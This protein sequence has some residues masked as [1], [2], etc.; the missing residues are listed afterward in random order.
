M[1]DLINKKWRSDV[2][3]SQVTLEFY[4]FW[5]VCTWHASWLKLTGKSHLLEVNEAFDEKVDRTQIIKHEFQFGILE[6]IT[7]L[8]YLK[9][10][11]WRLK[12]KYIFK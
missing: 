9:Q 5:P 3:D 1:S 2:F 6:L 10:I 11:V 12:Y 8:E 4:R 7:K